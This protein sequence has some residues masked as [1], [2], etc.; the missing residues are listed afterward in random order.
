MSNSNPASGYKK[1]REPFK[2]FCEFLS[3][4]LWVAGAAAMFFIDSKSKC[5]WLPDFL[6]LV[7]FC[8]LLF[9][10]RPSWPWFL[11]GILNIVIG[12]ELSLARL[13]PLTAFPSYLLAVR[14]YLIEHHP[15]D[16]WLLVGLTSILYGV[17]RLV[18]NLVL[19]FNKLNKA[20]C[21]R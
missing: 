3:A 11:F 9:Y 17:L 1:S 15:I 8:P 16:P 13:L 18:K 2:R 6:L 14:Q 20:S 19:R 21:S 4:F 7:G 10:W 12:V 5:P